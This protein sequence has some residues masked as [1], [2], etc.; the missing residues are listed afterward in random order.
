MLCIVR[1]ECRS[2]TGQNLHKLMR[3]PDKRRIDDQKKGDFDDLI[4][5][6]IPVCEEWKIRLAE[7]LIE[8]KYG[9]I[10]VEILT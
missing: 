4:Y 6:E 5:N 8:M 3:I 9:I 2:N 1:H 10:D 7:E